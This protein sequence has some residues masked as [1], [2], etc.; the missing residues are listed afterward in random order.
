MA[1]PASIPTETAPAPTRTAA[2]N[3]V[4]AAQILV[5]V[6]FAA[7]L[8]VQ[9]GINPGY[10]ISALVADLQKP[11]MSLYLLAHLSPCQA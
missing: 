3:F 4:S 10:T 7:G 6:A 8:S 11:A 5:L 2:D 1:T 9:G